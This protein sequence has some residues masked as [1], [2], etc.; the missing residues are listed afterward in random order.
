METHLSPCTGRP[1]S[2]GSG[3]MNKD[4]GT[5]SVHFNAAAPKPQNKQTG[6]SFCMISRLRYQ[7]V[8]YSEVTKSFGQGTELPVPKIVRKI[9]TSPHYQLATKGFAL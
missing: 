6:P 9:V 8:G 7:S 1:A 3:E 4:E 2:V 5:E